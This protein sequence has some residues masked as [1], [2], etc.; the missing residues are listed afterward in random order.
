[1][2]FFRLAVALFM[3]W[4]SLNAFAEFPERPIKILV[5]FAAGGVADL[6]ARV[7]A[8]KISE[9]S[10]KT[11]IVENKTGAGGRIGYEAGAK[12]PQ[13]GYTFVATDVTYS[14]MPALYPVL[15][16]NASTDL[17][18]V[19]LLAEMPFVI[20]VR[21]SAKITTLA[22]LLA[23]AKA[24]PGKLNYGSAGIGSV[25]HVV[26]ELFRR[27]AEVDMVHV[28]YRGM[29]EAI[30]GLLGG[31]VDVLITA[32]PTA[33]GQI[34]GGKIRA[35]G[36]TAAMRS[37]ALPNAPTI[38][39]ARIN[40]VASNWI[41][42]TAPKGSPQEAIDWMQ[43]S[44]ASAVASGDVKQIFLNQGAEPSGTGAGEFGKLMRSETVRWTDVIR[45]SKITAE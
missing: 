8:Q 10:G 7:V 31:S 15:P 38:R 34:K 33:M 43:K 35:L 45:A 42:L 22:Q 4:Q 9:Q 23:N 24:A 2:T 29:G 6:L 30:S 26:T 21:E 14:M 3:G 36:V 32:V 18:P 39:E 44:V 20:A 37:P 1:M 16:W 28:P 17:V 13:D 12:A 19:A 25:N 41:G 40:F 27:T 5:P 11:V